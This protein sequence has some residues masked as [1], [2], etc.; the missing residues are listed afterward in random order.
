MCPASDVPRHWR[1]ASIEIR[2]TDPNQINGLDGHNLTGRFRDSGMFWHLFE[3]VL[4][5]CISKGLVGGEGFA[6]DASI[7]P[8]DANRQRGLIPGDIASGAHEVSE[9]VTKYLAALDAD[10][11]PS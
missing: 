11:K 2:G 4:G 1:R 8:A 9:N 10:A 6:V 3:T 5:R 7:I